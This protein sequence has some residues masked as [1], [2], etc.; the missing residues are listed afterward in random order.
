[1]RDHISDDET[2]QYYDPKKQQNLSLL[3]KCGKCKYACDQASDLKLHKCDNIVVM[4]D[5]RNEDRIYDS[6]FS[7]G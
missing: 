6:Q 4:N 1:M 3:Y 5:V 7:Q 2:V